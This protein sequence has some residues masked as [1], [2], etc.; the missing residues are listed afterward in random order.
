MSKY[1]ISQ[2]QGQLIIDPIT[3]QDA[4]WNLIDFFTK[5]PE[6]YNYSQL[7]AHNSVDPETIADYLGN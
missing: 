7:S 2:V 6:F 3:K 5:N 4:V 1:I